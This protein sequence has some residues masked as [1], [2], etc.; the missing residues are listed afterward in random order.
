MVTSNFLEKDPGNSYIGKCDTN[1]FFLLALSN[2]F[3]IMAEQTLKI[4][5]IIFYL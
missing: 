3:I 5:K 1:F 4:S 2:D